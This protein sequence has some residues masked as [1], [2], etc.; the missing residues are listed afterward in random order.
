MDVTFVESDKWY[1]SHISSSSLHRE[2][3]DEE[4]KW[5]TGQSEE[6]MV[7]AA[8]PMVTAA[9]TV[10]T[11][12]PS[13]EEET[14]ATAAPTVVP[15]T[16][17]QE[18]TGAAI[19]Q[20]GDNTVI[21]EE[22]EMTGTS[23]PVT[24]NGLHEDIMIIDSSDESPSR[25]TPLLAVPDNGNLFPENIPEVSPSAPSLKN[26]LDITTGYH[27]PFRSNR[28]KAPARYSPEETRKKSKY[29]ISNHMTTKGWPDPLINFA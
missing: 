21:I 2:T 28:D 23:S 18:E 19:T 17:S 9:P 29:P 6:T 1:S 12:P 26:D 14:M 15:V 24:D 27:L 10:V 25:R 22:E 4:Q 5:W 20:M 16:P 13:Q 11:I 8:P 3:Y 7:M